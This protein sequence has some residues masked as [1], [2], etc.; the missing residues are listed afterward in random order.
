MAEA[1]R[2]TYRIQ[3]RGGVDF[4]TVAAA[5]PYLARLGI[6]HLYLSP[7]WRAR[8]GST[9]GY[10]VVDPNAIEPAL[11][12]EAG[13]RDLA[14]RAKAAGLGIILDHVPNHMG[15]GADNAWWWDVLRHGRA[16]AFA[17]HFDIDWEATAG[18]TPGRLLLPVL[19]APYGEVLAA[20][21]LQ[22][23]AT[24]G[25]FELCYHDQRF[26]LRA[27]AAPT[28]VGELH[29]LLERQ[30][31]RLA[32]WRL[33]GEALNYRRFFDIDGPV[34]VRVEDEA[35]FTDTHRL[36]LA[37]V[38]EGPQGVRLDHIDGLRDPTA[39]LRRLDAAL[40]EATG[41][42]PP[43]VWPRRS[44]RATNG[45]APTGRS[46]ALPATRPPI[47]LPGSSSPATAWGAGCP[48]ARGRAQAKPILRPCSGTARRWSSAPAS[49]ASSNGWSPRPCASP[50]PTPGSGMS[51]APA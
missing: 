32:Y 21:E 42:A 6:S 24:A 30:A 40:R 25:G 43:P 50:Q 48:L 36:L 41:G 15:V 49:P 38:A 17:G 3:L 28:G 1:V 18:A 16:S 19:G 37:L 14:A 11:G 13:F 39:Y 45:S 29:A 27:D 26:P 12:G 4:A 5:I 22:V 9:H 35:V 2:A 33:G 47:A 8:A 31:Y 44:R 7:I 10:D 23:L 46:P 51:A 34:G 20:G